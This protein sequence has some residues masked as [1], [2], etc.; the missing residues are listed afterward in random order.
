MD[1]SGEGYTKISKLVNLSLTLELM[2][3]YKCF[4]RL[5]VCSIHRLGK[6]KRCH[7]PR[8]YHLSTVFAEEPGIRNK[9]VNRAGRRSLSEPQLFVTLP[10]E[11]QHIKLFDEAGRQLW[12][13]P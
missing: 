13:E 1:E 11:P 3:R 5:T 12:P 8:T 4:L 10:F 7:R 6:G 2:R 9:E